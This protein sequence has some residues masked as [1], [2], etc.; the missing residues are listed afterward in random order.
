MF[1]RRSIQLLTSS[2]HKF[3]EKSGVKYSLYCLGAYG[4]NYEDALGLA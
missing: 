1:A 2:K 3:D 4:G